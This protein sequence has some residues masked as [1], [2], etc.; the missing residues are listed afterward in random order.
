MLDRFAAFLDTAQRILLTTHEHPDGDGTGAMVGLAH[1]LRHQG[2]EVRI[3]VSPHLPASLRFMDTEGWIEAYDEAAHA[4]LQAWPDAWVL[5]DASEPKRLGKMLSQFQASKAV[6]V[7]LDHHVKDAP[8][9]FD[10]EFTDATASASAQLVARMAADRM[11]RPLPA[12]MAQAL[13][14]GIVDDTGNFRFSNATADVHRIA[15][16]LIDDGVEPARIYQA[17][18][19]QG[20]PEK[21]KIQGRAFE[22]MALMEGGTYARMSLSLQDMADCQATHDDLE[23]LVNKPLELAGVEV[24]CLL[25]EQGPDRV[26]ISLRSRERVNVNAVARLFDGGGHILASGARIAADLEEAGRRLD[27]EVSRQLSRDL[28]DA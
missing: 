8:M 27:A 12:A 15:A 4:D 3:V 7:C 9:G 6:K 2:K 10:L 21:L 13:Y 14:T 5:V 11:S 1:Y 16:D 20:R 19:H 18:Y 28:P 22:R 25:E 26:K 23:G 24:S 17:L